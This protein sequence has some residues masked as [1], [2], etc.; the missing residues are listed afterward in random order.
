MAGRIFILSPA[1]CSGRRGQHLL[2]ADSSGSMVAR[3]GAESGVPLGEL[4]TYI[5]GLYFRGKLAY[6]SRFAAVA[7][8]SSAGRIHIITPTDGL[9]GP[10]TP[11]TLDDVRRFASQAIDVGNAVYHQALE[12]AARALHASHPDAEVIL[13]GSI[14][15]PKYVDILLDVFAEQLLFPSEF[16]GRGDMSRGGLMLRCVASGEELQYARVAGAL[17]TGARPPKLTPL[18]GRSGRAPIPDEEMP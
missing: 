2:R 7:P 16:V 3:L 17:R 9:R 6:A 18:R 1:N 13:L 10:D 8:S 4:F 5:S 11:V 15:S 12:S 14:A